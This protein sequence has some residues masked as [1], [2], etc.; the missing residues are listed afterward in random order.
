[1]KPK[2]VIKIWCG[3]VNAVIAVISDRLVNADI[4]IVD[5]DP[6]GS[7]FEEYQI[8]VNPDEVSKA[9]AEAE[10]SWEEELND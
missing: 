4:L 5:R 8:A 1:M 6:D 9:Y 3:L 7:K 2:I 10:D